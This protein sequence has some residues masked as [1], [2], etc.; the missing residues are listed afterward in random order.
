M[1]DGVSRLQVEETS[2]H[3]SN[4]TP[5]YDLIL[6]ASDNGTA[7]IPVFVGHAAENTE[8]WT[9]MMSWLPDFINSISGALYRV[10]CTM[11]QDAIQGVI[12]CHV[13]VARAALEY[14]QGAEGVYLDLEDNCMP[15]QRADFSLL[16]EAK[17]TLLAHPEWYFIHTSRFPAPIALVDPETSYSTPLWEYGSNIY[18]KLIGTCELAQAMLDHTDHAARIADPDFA[19]VAAYDD[20]FASE[21]KH[22]VYPSIFQRRTEDETATT[23]TPFFQGGLG[24]TLRNICFMPWVYTT[25]DVI[26]AHGA[27]F[28][29]LLFPVIIIACLTGDLA[30]A[31]W[32]FAAGF[33]V[34]WSLGFR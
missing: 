28:S 14:Y 31:A 16:E 12:D 15:S 2:A 32:C 18:Q 4:A 24:K 8:R 1:E 22:V 20:Q 7:S 29:C 23:A 26:N 9:Q 17:A 19:W 3:A 10:N 11:E 21:M 5:A 25:I 13:L 6:D 30:I 33:V 34:C 27:W